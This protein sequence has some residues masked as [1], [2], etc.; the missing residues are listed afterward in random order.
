MSIKEVR[1]AA[2]ITAMPATRHDT[3]HPST[4][5]ETGQADSVEVSLSPQAVAHAKEQQSPLAESG[6]ETRDN[7]RPG[8]DFYT[9]PVTASD[10]LRFQGFFQNARVNADDMADALHKA[11]IS[12]VDNGDYTTSAMDLALAQGKLNRV[13]AQYVT[14]DYQAQASAFV[15]KF[16][17]D[18]ATQADQMSK[19]V[20]SQATR[21]A[22]SL[23]D[24]EQA[25]HHQ[26]AVAQLAEGTHSS[27]RIRNE[28]LSLTAHSSDSETWFSTLSGWVNENRSLPYIIEIEKS[29]V[30][31]LQAQWQAFVGSLKTDD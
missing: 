29:H 3:A 1:S 15:A 11:L 28:M 20:L 22:Q 14:A 17:N 23:G 5:K 6:Q 7:P 4:G 8:G 12:P 18:K 16:I 9:D 21:L 24:S 2:S 19:V 27:Q 31:A 30:G 13:V 10:A 26:D 25:R